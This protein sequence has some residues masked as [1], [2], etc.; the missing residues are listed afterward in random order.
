MCGFLNLFLFFSS[1]SLTSLEIGRPLALTSGRECMGIG[2]GWVGLWID[3]GG[4]GI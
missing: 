1:A 4:G 2:G 3:N